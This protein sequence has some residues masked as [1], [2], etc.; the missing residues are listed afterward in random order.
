MLENYIDK[1]NTAFYSIAIKF[2]T[3]SLFDL[4]ETY[5]KLLNPALP[6]GGEQRLY[7]RAHLS[8]KMLTQDGVA[9]R[10]NYPQGFLKVKGY[11][12][13]N[14]FMTTSM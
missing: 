13:R 5:H 8:Q 9:K 11:A 3:F 6:F 1:D 2:R 14:F 7:L 4:T 12:F 10:L